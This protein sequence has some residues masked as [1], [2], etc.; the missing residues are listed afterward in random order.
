MVRHIIDD[1]PY[2]SV[3]VSTKDQE[4]PAPQLQEYQ[5]QVPNLDRNNFMQNLPHQSHENQ[6][7]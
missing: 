4:S 6:A 2:I 1:N 3:K 5:T 7:I